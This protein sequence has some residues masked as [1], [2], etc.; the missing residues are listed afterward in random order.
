MDSEKNTSPPSRFG[1]TDGRPSETVV[2]AVGDLE[3]I[4]PTELPPLYEAIEPK[5]LDRAYRDLD[6]ACV[7]FAYT[8]YE[9]TVTGAGTVVLRKAE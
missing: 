8:G 2:T 1:I 4:E 3:G 7:T 5:S 6:D 9:V